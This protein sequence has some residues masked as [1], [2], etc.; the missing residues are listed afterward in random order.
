MPPRIVATVMV[1]QRLH[2]LSDRE[3][4]EAFEFDARWKYACGGLDFDLSAEHQLI[5]A[6]VREFA[7]QQVAPVAADLDREH[8]FPYELVAELAELGLMGMPIPE[9]DH[10]RLYFTGAGSRALLR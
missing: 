9:R 5:R 8:R 7:E 4:V 6:T 1:L 3:A 10:E 2:G